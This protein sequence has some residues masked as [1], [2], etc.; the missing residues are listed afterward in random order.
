MFSS[1]NEAR[2]SLSVIPDSSIPDSRIYLAN[3]DELMHMSWKREGKKRDVEV[4]A[5]YT[6]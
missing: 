1:V 6:H 5:Y 4:S 3:D 2:L